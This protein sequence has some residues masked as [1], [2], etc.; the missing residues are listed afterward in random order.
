MFIGKFLVMIMVHIQ[1]AATM[2]IVK[3]T[4]VVWLRYCFLSEPYT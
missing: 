4:D 1:A 3:N 2:G